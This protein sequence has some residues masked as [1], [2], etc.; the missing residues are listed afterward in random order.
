MNTVLY[1]LLTLLL[2]SIMVV[3]H[4]LGHFLFA[5]L[6]KVTVLEFSVGMGPA[7]FT[8]K[9][10]KNAQEN[11]DEREGSTLPL[12]DTLHEADPA[13]TDTD[14]ENAYE[15]EGAEKTVFSVRALPIGGYVSMAGEE[16]ASNDINAFCNT[17]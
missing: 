1:L 4:E 3:I 5:K 14:A 2:L 7:I 17:F 8:T 15:I 6:F 9:K 16:E 10:K 13:P 12:A 11:T